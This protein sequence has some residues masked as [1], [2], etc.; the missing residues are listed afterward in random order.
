[1]AVIIP[2]FAADSLLVA[3][4][5]F[6]ATGFLIGVPMA[7]LEAIGLDIVVP[8]LRGRASAVRAVLRVGMTASAPVAFG[9][10]SD[11]Y[12]LRVAILVLSPTMLLGGLATFAAG[13]SYGRDA[14]HAQAEALRQ[15][16][17]QEVEGS[18]GP[19]P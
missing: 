11:A 8:Q 16:D 1:M 6:L 3:V 9:F 17:L 18:Y 15:L 10:L 7:P 4:P 13:R 2:A 14:A 5:F 19:R 12:D